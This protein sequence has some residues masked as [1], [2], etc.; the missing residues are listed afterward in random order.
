MRTLHRH[1]DPARTTPVGLARYAAEFMEAALAADDKMGV[2]SG[3][4]II[5]PVPVM[6]LVGQAVELALKSYLLS[7]GVTLR[8]LR[9]DYGHQLHRAL[10]RAKELGLLSLIELSEEELAGLKYLDHLYS[11]RE[12]QYIV[13]G[14]KQFP[15]F[16][17]VESAALRLIHAIGGAVGYSPR[18]LP[19]VV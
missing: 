1:E 15:V 13:T 10:R 19:H 6:F 8:E 18:N 4:E 17:P 14:V 5:A 12:L 7:R 3:Y 9:R 11:T 16:G 2:R